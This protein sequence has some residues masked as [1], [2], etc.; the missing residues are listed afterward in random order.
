ML[1]FK[2]SNIQITRGDSAYIT[3]NI[4]D[5]AGSDV[6]LGENDT[7][8]CQVREEPNGGTI[9]FEGEIL[10]ED[11]TFTWH[12]RPED[13]KDAP[14]DSY[15]WDAQIELENGDIFSFIPVSCFCIIPEVTEEEV[16]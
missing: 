11:S 1:K 10:R 12:I 16:P 5:I 8:R 15:Y 14:K 6:T 13:T 2:K 9:L 7:V 4:K 3:L